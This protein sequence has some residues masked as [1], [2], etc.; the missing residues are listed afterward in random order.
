M[1][2]AIKQE[3]DS[4]P[5][6]P[7]PVPG[8]SRTCS[9]ITKKRQRDALQECREVLSRSNKELQELLEVEELED[10]KVY[11]DEYVQDLRSQLK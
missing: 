5:E 2:I 9:K 3:P 7:P 1:A 8:P 6:S 4:P 10:E 11:E